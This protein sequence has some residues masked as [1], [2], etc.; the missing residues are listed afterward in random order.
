MGESQRLPNG[1]ND[2]RLDYQEWH[3]V[4]VRAIAATYVTTHALYSE[5]KSDANDFFH[6]AGRR[7]GFDAN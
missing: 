6:C 4:S 7:T 3:D 2:R 5:A 1:I